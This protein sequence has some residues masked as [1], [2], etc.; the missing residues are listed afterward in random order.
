MTDVM[1]DNAELI[2]PVV[3]V[4]IALISLS[5]INFVISIIPGID[6]N[7]PG[8]MWS[9]PTL[10]SVVIACIMIVIVLRFGFSIVP[11]LQAKF[12]NVPEIRPIV[13]NLVFLIC[14]GIAYG[15]F[16]GLVSPFLKGFT[17]LYSIAFLV[18]GLILAY[19]IATTLMKSTDKWTDMLIHNVKTATVEVKV[20]Q[21]CGATNPPANK[22]CD[23][24]GTPIN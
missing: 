12:P 1:E 19:I 24:C 13:L 11:Q 21:K 7:I 17:W 2:K 15:P 20:C 6:V 4:V 10:I 5:I 14:L 8:F 22:F 3:R 9:I 18:V 16:Q 23:K